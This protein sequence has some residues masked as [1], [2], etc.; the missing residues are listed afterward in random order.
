MEFQTNKNIVVLY[1][2]KCP[3]GFSGAWAAWKKFGDSAEYVPVP[4][5]SDAPYME[6]K[7]V[8]CIDYIPDNPS[9]L[10]DFISQNKS[11]IA[12]DHH[13]SNESLVPLFTSSKFDKS[14]CGSILAWE[15]FFPEQPVPILLKYIQDV[16]LWQWKLSNS[17]ELALYVGTV[18]FTF[19][20][21]EQLCS[22]FENEKIRA[23]IIKQAQLLMK[24][25]NKHIQNSIEDDAQL[26]IFEGLEILAINATVD[27]SFMGN[28]LIERKPPMSI[29]WMESKDDVHVGLRS[30]GDVDVSVIAKKYGGGGHLKA[31]GFGWPLGKENPWKIIKEDEK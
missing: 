14:K 26:V 4:P 6:G 12:I 5:G 13:A 7:E 22:D 18:D 29:V 15:Y 1:H 17:N 20:A 2:K 31:S 11:V 9:G 28:E 16:D 21:W 25:K 24:Y 8:Y 23:D 27:G 19:P 10:K 3:D 30:N